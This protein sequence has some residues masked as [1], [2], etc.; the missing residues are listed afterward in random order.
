VFGIKRHLR[1][2][3]AMIEEHLLDRIVTDPAIC[4]GRPTLRGTRIRVSD[5]LEM[6]AA[7]M[8]HAEIT[9]DYPELSQ[10]DIQATALYASRA[11]AHPVIRAA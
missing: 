9:A 8:T 11:V 1:Y 4:G 10:T 6:V 7:G 3:F 2:D 5:V